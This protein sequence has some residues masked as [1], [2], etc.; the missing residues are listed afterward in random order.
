MTTENDDSFAAMFEREAAPVRKRRDA[1]IGQLVSGQVVSVGRDAVFVEIDGGQQA[2]FE[3]VDLRGPDGTLAVAEGD[4][5]DAR[6]VD[7]DPAR[8]LVRLE[9]LREPTKVNKVKRS[10]RSTESSGPDP[11][12]DL[13]VVEG[14]VVDG[15]V[16]RTTD[17]GAFVRVA[18]GIEG[19][20]HVSEVGKGKT[21]AAEEVVRVAAKKIDREARKISLVLAPDGAEVGSFVATKLSVD[22]GAVVTGT[23]ERIET[24]G[25]FVQVDGTKGRAGRGLVPNAELGVPRGT[26][27]RKAFPEGTKVKAKVLETGEGRLRLSIRGAKDAEERA[28]FEASRGRGAAPASLGTFADLLKGR[29]L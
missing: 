1:R 7:V 10:P 12:A 19:L 3:A 27:V 22:V 20:L 8:E 21:L 5:L 17:F 15:T 24:Y 18:P 9:R 28:D 16:V 23:V 13:P 4:R 11:W 29:K 26:D 2:F 14:R 6:V 25:V